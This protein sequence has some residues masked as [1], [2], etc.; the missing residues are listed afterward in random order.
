MV[1]RSRP[2]ANG[3]FASSLRTRRGARS[4]SSRSAT[5]QRGFIQSWE[6]SGRER[7]MIR[8]TDIAPNP[9]QPAN[10]AATVAQIANRSFGSLKIPNHGAFGETISRTVLAAASARG[11]EI[12]DV[13][14]TIVGAA[15]GTASRVPGP[16]EVGAAKDGV[17]TSAGRIASRIGLHDATS[18]M[19]RRAP[20]DTT[21]TRCREIAE[22]RSITRVTPSAASSTTVALPR[23]RRTERPAEVV[24]PENAENMAGIVLLPPADTRAADALAELVDFAVTQ[25]GVRHSEKR[26]D[27]LLGGTAE[28]RTD[29]VLQRIVTR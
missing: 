14:R 26:R 10:S 6:S 24:S 27:G 15:V 2:H 22:P 25:V 17:A 28:I 11:V 23:M 7:R 16:Y 13:G 1:G 19:S 5:S 12:G 18:G 3:I 4:S 8:R 21:H 9:S 20:S 29:H